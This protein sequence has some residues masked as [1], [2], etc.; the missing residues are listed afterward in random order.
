L[1]ENPWGFSPRGV[2][3][4]TVVTSPAPVTKQG[5]RAIR[6]QPG[7]EWSFFVTCRFRS[8]RAEETR[9]DER[10]NTMQVRTTL[11]SNLWPPPELE[12]ARAF[13]VRRS[14]DF[15]IA[16]LQERRDAGRNSVSA[17]QRLVR[18]PNC[19][20]SSPSIRATPAPAT[21]YT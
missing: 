16:G 13:V 9:M 20:R 7:D 14:R 15:Y 19:P 8:D 18:A 1:P 6:F 12:Q 5:K 10:A 3:E 17:S 21:N 11:K 2:S 4:S